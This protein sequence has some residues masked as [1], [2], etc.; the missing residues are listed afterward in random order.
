MRRQH[1]MPHHYQQ[2]LMCWCGGVSDLWAYFVCCVLSDAIHDQGCQRAD[3]VEPGESHARHG[4]AALLHQHRRLS[5]RSAGQF[6]PT[7]RT[8]HPGAM[9]RRLRQLQAQVR[10][11]QAPWMQVQAAA[12]ARPICSWQCAVQQQ[13]ECQF[14]GKTWRR[15]CVCGFLDLSC[16]QSAAPGAEAGTDITQPARLLIA[17]V[18]GLRVSTAVPY[19]HS[20]TPL[21]CALSF[22]GLSSSRFCAVLHCIHQQACGTFL[23]SHPYCA[24]ADM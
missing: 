8:Q 16:R 17:A 11:C 19:H 6:L 20:C 13:L 14:V 23:R 1:A 10:G 5:P 3:R 24:D 4:G 22:S 7:R 15:P 2:V 12:S 18:K 21:H 9:R